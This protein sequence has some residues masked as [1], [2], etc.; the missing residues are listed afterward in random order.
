MITLILISSKIIKSRNDADKQILKRAG[1]NKYAAIISGARPAEPD[2][3]GNIIGAYS[4]IDSL[5]N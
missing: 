5:I 1:D 3:L 2:S 4:K